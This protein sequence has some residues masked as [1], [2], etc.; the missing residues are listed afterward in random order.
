[1]RYLGINIIKYMQG[2]DAEKYKTQIKEI[3]I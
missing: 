1:M 3:N 2:L